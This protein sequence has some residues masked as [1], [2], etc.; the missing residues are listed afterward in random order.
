MCVSFFGE[1]RLQRG[2]KILTPHLCALLFINYCH[3]LEP[4]LFSAAKTKAQFHSRS[5]VEFRKHP[6]SLS[7]AMSPGKATRSQQPFLV[8]RN[9]GVTDDTFSQRI[10]VAV[11]ANRGSSLLQPSSIWRPI[12]G[13][14]T[15]H[16]GRSFPSLSRGRKMRSLR[17]RPVH[18]R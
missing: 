16:A 14:H 9:S 10:F 2:K 12:A 17:L 8:Q 7:A 3:A 5:S 6:P 13:R 4:R 18:A 15:R 11:V 1:I